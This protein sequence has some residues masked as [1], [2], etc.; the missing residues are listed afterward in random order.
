MQ[1]IEVQYR[2]GDR[3][4]VPAWGQAATVTTVMVQTAS[5]PY[6]LV[7]GGGTKTSLDT[8]WVTADE[9]EPLIVNGKEITP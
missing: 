1:T 4:H 9:I 6:Y 8:A 3:V 2:P 5:P 7:V